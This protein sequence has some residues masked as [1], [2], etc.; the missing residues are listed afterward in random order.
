[1]LLANG[2]VVKTLGTNSFPSSISIDFGFPDYLPVRPC[3]SAIKPG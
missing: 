2:K 3:E 1:M